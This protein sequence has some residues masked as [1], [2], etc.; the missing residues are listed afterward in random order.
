MKKVQISIDDDLLERVDN[1]AE[2]NYMSRSGLI[3]V[4]CNQYLNQFEVVLAIKDLSLAMQK[5]AKDKAINEDLIEQLEDFER[6][7]RMLL[8]K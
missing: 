4:A 2:S 7:S 3:T 6:V 5:I 8:E 1:Y